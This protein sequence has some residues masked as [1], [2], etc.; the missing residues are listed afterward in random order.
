MEW[1]RPYNIS[2]ESQFRAA[3]VN[4]S[5]LQ[6]GESCC[7]PFTSP[8]LSLGRRDWSYVWEAS[9]RRCQAEH[10]SGVWGRKEQARASLG[11]PRALISR[12][13]IDL[14]S[15]LPVASTPTP[16]PGL[17]KVASERFTEIKRTHPGGSLIRGCKLHPALTHMETEAEDNRECCPWK[18]NQTPS[19]DP[20]AVSISWTGRIETRGESRSERGQ[21]QEKR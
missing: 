19:L 10:R 20:E 14:L 1:L 15:K 21:S 11:P 17:S 5:R 2:E 18:Q 7:F 13:G 9:K 3:S 12:P 4:S 16:P 6:R 8:S